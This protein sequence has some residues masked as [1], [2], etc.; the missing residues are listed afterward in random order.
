M[1]SYR[2]IQWELNL[3]GANMLLMGSPN[4]DIF[5]HAHL[6]IMMNINHAGHMALLGSAAGST[7]VHSF[8]RYRH[9]PGMSPVQ[10]LMAVR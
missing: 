5:P 2:L 4:V 1:L 3:D 6:Q 10:H 7:S 8:R 9:P